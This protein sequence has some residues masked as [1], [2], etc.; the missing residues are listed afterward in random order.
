VPQGTVQ[1]DPHV[2][3][4]YENDRW[5]CFYGLLDRTLGRDNFTPFYLLPWPAVIVGTLEE[6]TAKPL[7]EAT[8]EAIEI[9]GLIGANSA[10]RKVAFTDPARVVVLRKDQNQ[11]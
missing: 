10:L 7:Q 11:P 2:Q 3:K 9:C 5:Y 1:G 8:D 6:I 4:W